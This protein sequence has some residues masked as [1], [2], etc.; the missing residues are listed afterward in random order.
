MTLKKSRHFLLESKITNLRCAP[1]LL[2]AVLELVMA[3]LI[4]DCNRVYSTLTFDIR[5]GHSG[6]LEGKVKSIDDKIQRKRK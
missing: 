4:P 5:Q 6:R 1:S 2:K 3:V